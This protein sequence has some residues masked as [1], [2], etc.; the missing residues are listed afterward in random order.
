MK[1]EEGVSPIIATILMVAISVV[2]AVA[3][4]IAVLGNLL[5]PPYAADKLVGSLTMDPRY[6]YDRSVNFTITMTSPEKTF[7]SKVT[8][9]LVAG[10]GDA[11]SHLRYSPTADKWTNYTAG[12]KWHY[13]AKLIDLDADGNFSDGDR[14]WVYIVDDNSHDGISPPVF[15]TGDRVLFSIYDYHGVSS[16]GDIQM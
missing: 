7:K 2:L 15:H 13:E 1:R 9:T 5:V 8:I 6:S 10:E 12:S 14:L 3:L 16:G 4:Y 11:I